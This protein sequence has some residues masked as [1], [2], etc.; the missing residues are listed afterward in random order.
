MTDSNK[1]I[2]NDSPANFLSL[3]Q[4]MFTANPLMGPQAQHFW[5]VQDQF[6]KEAESFTSAWFKR[7]HDATRSAMDAASNIE[8]DKLL[9]PGHI[10]QVM[11]DWQ[12]HSMERLSDDAKEYNDMM[13]RCMDSLVYNEI[14]AAKETV[15]KS[16]RTSRQKDATPA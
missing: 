8:D 6:L 3:T 2:L 16:K 11:A 7:R 15:K 10:M 12:N 1:S 9:E 13:T 5:K 4:A 14:E